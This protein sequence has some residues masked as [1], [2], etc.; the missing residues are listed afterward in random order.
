MVKC[1]FPPLW[2]RPLKRGPHD[3]FSKVTS[4]T[5]YFSILFIKGT[6][7]G[8]FLIWFFPQTDTPGPIRDVQGRFD[9]LAFSWSYWT[10]KTT[11]WCLGHRGVDQKFLSQEKF[12]NLYKCICIVNATIRHFF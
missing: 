4:L 1:S 3:L 12:S 7:A 9:N 2:K 10:L 11:P 8:D 5:F 6:V